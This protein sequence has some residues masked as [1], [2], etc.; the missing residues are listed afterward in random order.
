MGPAPFSGQFDRFSGRMNARGM[1]GA[2]VCRML[3]TSNTQDESGVSLDATFFFVQAPYL[4]F[5][6]NCA[7]MKKQLLLCFLL[8]ACLYAQAQKRFGITGIV[9]DAATGEVLTRASVVSADGKYE[10]LTSDS[11]GFRMQVEE[12]SVMLLVT[13]IGYDSARVKVNATGNEVVRIALKRSVAVLGEVEVLPEL[14]PHLFFGSRET[15]V[16][17]YTFWM[18]HTLVVLYNYH[19]RRCYLV[20]LDRNNQ[21]VDEQPVPA[22]FES[23]Y[24]SCIDKTYALMSDGAVYE[25]TRTASGIGIVPFSRQFFQQKVPYYAGYYKE[26]F[27]LTMAS[28]SRQS[29][30]YF[31]EDT[32]N[33]IIYQSTPFSVVSNAQ[34]QRHASREEHRIDNDRVK[35]TEEVFPNLNTVAEG[36]YLQ[37]FTMLESKQGFVRRQFYKQQYL[38]RPLY[39]PLFVQDSTPIVFDFYR[40]RLTCYRADGTFLHELPIRFHHDSGWQSWIWRDA[41]TQRY[42]TGYLQPDERL[43]LCELGINDCVTTEKLTLHYPHASL[44]KV[45]KGYVYYLARPSEKANHVFLFRQRTGG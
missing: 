38:D 26:Y 30:V 16:L 8:I 27:Y 25:L 28:K 43:K 20:L 3:H 41:F 39:A 37:D 4:A 5:L 14:P 18:D 15:Q 7:T 22:N 42:Y 31:L 24:T 10:Q 12:K 19:R 2:A 34:R 40:D 32:K 11:G 6:I 21:V 17:D 29:R 44:V 33:R 36:D 13:Y 23:L 9:T 45:R 1:T 35:A